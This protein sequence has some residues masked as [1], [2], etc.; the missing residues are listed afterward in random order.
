M[1]LSKASD[2]AAGEKTELKQL[3]CA[4]DPVINQCMILSEAEW[5]NSDQSYSKEFCPQSNTS[6]VISI[7]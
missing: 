1:D 7:K 3:R 5:G 4:L 2:L 6:F